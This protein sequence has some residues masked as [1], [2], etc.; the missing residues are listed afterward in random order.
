MPRL[1]DLK[2]APALV[3]EVLEAL[4]V[5]PAAEVPELEPALVESRRDRWSVEEQEGNVTL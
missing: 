2:P 4:P 5:E 3:L 1:N